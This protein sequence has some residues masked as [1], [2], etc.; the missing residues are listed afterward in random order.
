MDGGKATRTRER[1][2]CSRRRNE[3]YKT[4]YGTGA[5]NANYQ[6][7]ASGKIVQPP[8]A[9]AVTQESLNKGS[10]SGANTYDPWGQSNAY[11]GK[12]VLQQTQDEQYKQVAKPDTSNGSG[13]TSVETAV[14]AAAPMETIYT[15]YV[16][17]RDGVRQMQT[18]GGTVIKRQWMH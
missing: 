9:P 7:N 5:V 17:A 10:A 11:T 18:Q 8:A 1:A 4:N 3:Q 13:E 2:Y 6:P 12:S 16:Q 15:S 14:K